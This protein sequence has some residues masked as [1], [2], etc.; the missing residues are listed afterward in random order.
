PIPVPQ[1]LEG[2]R[3]GDLTQD[4][5]IIV[6]EEPDAQEHAAEPQAPAQTEE[7]AVEPGALREFSAG[8]RLLAH[9]GAAR[10][11]RA[12]EHFQRA[13]QLDHYLWEAQYN[14]GLIQ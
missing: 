9:G 5:P 1:P 12:L 7:P 11:E 3:R 4:R 2:L 8:A 13:L 6:V 14:I 10:E